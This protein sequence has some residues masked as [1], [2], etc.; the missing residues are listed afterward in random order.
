MGKKNGE[1]LGQAAT[2]AS[3]AMRSRFGAEVKKAREAAN[4]A[5]YE[6]AEKVGVSFSYVSM[7]ERG[8][9]E[10]SFPVICAVA[11]ALKAKPARLLFAPDER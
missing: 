9:R 1:D 6:L 11:A 3:D 5:Q 4:M 10:P 2:K 7:L 8:E